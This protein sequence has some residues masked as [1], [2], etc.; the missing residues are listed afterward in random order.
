MVFFSLAVR[1]HHFQSSNRILLE[2]GK[3]VGKKIEDA[4]K[5]TANACQ[6]ITPS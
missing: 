6:H 1:S 2:K 5:A 4:I 3:A